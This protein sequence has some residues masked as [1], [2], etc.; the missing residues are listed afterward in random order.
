MRSRP[1]RIA[2]D[3]GHAR[4]RSSWRSMRTRSSRRSELASYLTRRA[5]AERALRHRRP[6]LGQDG[7]GQVDLERR[8][9]SMRAGRPG[10]PMHLVADVQDPLRLRPLDPCRLFVSREISI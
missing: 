5:R 10:P 7:G 2:K 9:A 1:G 8:E 3:G 4:A 6:A